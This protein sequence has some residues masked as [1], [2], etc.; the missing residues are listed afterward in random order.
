AGR[1]SSL[2]R[3][4]HAEVPS[5]LTRRDFEMAHKAA[6]QQLRTGKPAAAPDLFHTVFGRCELSSGGFDANSLDIAC[7]RVTELESEHPGEVTGAHGRALRE[8]LDREIL[9]QILRDPDL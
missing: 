1:S 8:N 3:R 5:I 6:T 4:R 2:R 9:R 7:R